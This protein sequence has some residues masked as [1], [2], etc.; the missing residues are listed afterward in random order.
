MKY[1]L[2]SLMLAGCD[3]PGLPHWQCINGVLHRKCWSALELRA[4]EAIE[5]LLAE[6]S[7]V[8]VQISVISKSNKARSN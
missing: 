8:G 7:V 6:R 3:D 1:L 5:K 2:A 4:L